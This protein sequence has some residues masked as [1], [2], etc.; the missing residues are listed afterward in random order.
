MRQFSQSLESLL[1]PWGIFRKLKSRGGGQKLPLATIAWHLALLCDFRYALLPKND[2]GTTF[3]KKSRCL[4]SMMGVRCGALVRYACS[5]RVG[6]CVFC[7]DFEKN[8]VF[9]VVALHA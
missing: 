8:L 1:I 9:L 6:F 7:A 4:R 3:A 5:K 2:V